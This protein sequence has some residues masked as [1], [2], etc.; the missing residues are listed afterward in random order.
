MSRDTTPILIKMSFI[1]MSSES[2]GAF[3]FSRLQYGSRLRLNLKTLSKLTCSATLVYLAVLNGARS[4]RQRALTCLL[5]GTSALITVSR[6]HLG[7]R[8]VRLR[9]IR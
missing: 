1:G 5:R 9:L 8:Q 2:N 4:K 7:L 6:L 3:R